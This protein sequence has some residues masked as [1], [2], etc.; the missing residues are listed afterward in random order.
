MNLV[1]L[2]AFMFNFQINE[3]NLTGTLF[4]GAIHLNI[5]EMFLFKNKW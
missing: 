2:F 4:P 5:S 3:Q 1:L